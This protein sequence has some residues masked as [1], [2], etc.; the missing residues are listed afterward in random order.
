MRLDEHVATREAAVF[1]ARESELGRLQAFLDTNS[2]HRVVFLTGPAGCGKSAVLREL[3][4]RAPAHGYSV[5]ALDAR[6]QVADP[7]RLDAALSEASDL[8]RPLVLLDSAELLGPEERRLRE[9]HLG[10]LPSTARV[11]LALRGEAEPGWWTSAWAPSLLALPVPAF[12]S[13]AAA[14]FLAA[15]GIRDESEVSRLT[16]WAEG[17]ALSLTLA[18]AARDSSGR[19]LAASDLD[20]LERDLLD[21]LTGGRLADPDLVYGDR[22]V[23][24]VA[25]LAPSVDAEL[26]SAVLPDTAGVPA[27]R[28][29]RGLPFAERLGPRVTLHQRVRRLIA[30]QLRRVDPDLERMLRLRIID[31]LTEASHTGRPHLAIEIREVLAPPQDRG[32]TPSMALASAWRVDTAT[33][34]DVPTLR[35]LLADRD[36]AYAA[37]IVGWIREAP[38]QVILVRQPGAGTAADDVVALALWTTP[39]A[40]SR[41]Q[42]E[43]VHLR[44][45][46]DWASERDPDGRTLLNPVNEL[47]VGEDL[48]DEVNA[49]ALT[50]LVQSCGLPNF[51][52]WIVP[53]NPPAADPL[54][55]GGVRTPE[56]DLTFGELR[57]DTY[58]LD[59]GSSGVIPAMQ[60]Q[61][62][63]DLA[64]LTS[65]APALVS[66]AAHVETV[67]HAL[68][69]FHDPLAL[70]ASPLAR[71]GD[72]GS[73]ARY[74]SDLI[75]TAVDEAFGDHADARLH[76]NVL[77]HG[78]LERDAGHARAMRRLHL[79]RTTYFRRLREATTRL[80]AWLA[81]R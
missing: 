78:Y 64:P 74:L 4:R 48:A 67:R 35:V 14:A 73:R 77:L 68:R 53:R 79:S 76:R 44:P 40:A 75:R 59:Y 23:L 61:A 50:A 13:G 26:L 52:H 8:D 45:W 54:H 22:A 1:V 10:R 25:A 30:A 29:L 60:A 5:V 24:A 7:D 27:E 41:E 3:A 18:S 80:A 31:H 38:Q 16:T 33:A 37:W 11:V 55:C 58:V 17:H 21:H 62:H 51:T 69:S 70:A 19:A 66:T 2:V 6:E 72:T 81:A 49:V 36:P 63:A 65:A 47:W 20:T 57:L 56:L 42:R 9:E 43:D 39:A 46:F 12:Q 28:W 32:V 71:G 34:A 15:R